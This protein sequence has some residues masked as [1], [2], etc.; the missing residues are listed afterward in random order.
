MNMT[1]IFRI[2]WKMHE[3]LITTLV[4]REKIKY[5]DDDN[6]EIKVVP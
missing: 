3:N 2:D 4:G 6:N 1:R 5:S